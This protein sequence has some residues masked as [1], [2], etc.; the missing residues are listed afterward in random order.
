MTLETVLLS[1][2][3]APPNSALFAS[4]GLVLWYLSVWK[5]WYGK[6]NM[7]ASRCINWEGLRKPRAVKMG[8]LAGPNVPVSWCQLHG[9]GERQVLVL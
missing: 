1:M 6:V 4:G 3:S 9:D 5:L 7:L 2:L 8:D